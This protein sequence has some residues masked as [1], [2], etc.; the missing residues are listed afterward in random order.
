MG[1]RTQVAGVT[2]IEVLI[3]ISILTVAL[4]ALGFSINAYVD[5]R[6]ALLNETKAT[7]LA[8]EGYETIRAIRD[9]NWNTIDA[10]SIGT[11]Y[12]FELSTTTLAIGATPEVIDGS[13]RRSFVVRS[14]YRN[15]SDDIV[16]STTAGAS[17]DDG[18]REVQVF[19]AGPTGTTSLSAILTNI[20]AI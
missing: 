18:S 3:G 20:H 1:A 11:T 13:F 6:T 8:E 10:L 17:I 12:Y 4:L 5:A 19:V 16:A 14:V 2:L 9:T 7:Y 15:A